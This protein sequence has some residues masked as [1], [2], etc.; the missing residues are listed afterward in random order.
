MATIRVTNQT[1]LLS[2]LKTA[3]GGDTILLANGNYGDVTLTNQFSSAVTIKAEHPQGATFTSVSLSKA[4]NMAFDGLKLSTSFSA[5]FSSDIS[6]TNSVT[7]Q[8]TVYARE[9]DGFVVDKVSATGGKFG[10]I[11]NS[12]QNFSVTNSTFGKF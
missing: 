11:M 5:M 9:V 8:G 2:A 6:L 1:Q 4:S 10:I 12:V 7:T 3:A